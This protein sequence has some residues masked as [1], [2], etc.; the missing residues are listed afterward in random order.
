MFEKERIHGVKAVFNV[1]DILLW[2]IYVCIVPSRK[3]NLFS[4][5]LCLCYCFHIH[6]AHEPRPSSLV[7]ERQEPK[8]ENENDG[9]CYNIHIRRIKYLHRLSIPHEMPILSTRI[10]VSAI[11]W[12]V[13][14]QRSAFGILLC[15]WDCMFGSQI[16]ELR[17]GMHMIYACHIYACDAISEW[18]E[19]I[20][21]W[22]F[23][24]FRV[25]WTL[26]DVNWFQQRDENEKQIHELQ[27]K[28]HTDTIQSTER[29]F[30]VVFEEIFTLAIL[31]CL[32]WNLLL[33]CF[34]SN[35]SN[36]VLLID[37]NA[38]AFAWMGNILFW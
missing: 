36:L 34:H 1:G 35:K 26:W 33:L 9:A 3:T 28:K 24:L 2:F 10:F 13:E 30:K 17:Q 8:Y 19:H 32:S 11:K 31:V 5:A 4:N 21:Y 29:M 6:G 14:M 15:Q 23:V 7:L 18:M 12:P 38:K 16:L 25:K 27:A 20:F 37:Y 22:V